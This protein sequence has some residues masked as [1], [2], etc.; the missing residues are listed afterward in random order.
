MGLLKPKRGHAKRLSFY[1]IANKIQGRYSEAFQRVIKWKNI[2]QAATLGS[3]CDVR[4]SIRNEG[5]CPEDII[6]NFGDDLV[7][8]GK[9]GWKVQADTLAHASSVEYQNK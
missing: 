9:H 2:W 7:R 3:E 1:R 4:N 8:L 5:P 6:A